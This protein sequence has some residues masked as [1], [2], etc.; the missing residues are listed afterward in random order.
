[1][2]KQRL[3]LLLVERNLI[4][5]RQQARAIIMS[6]IVEVE[7]RTITK[8]G[9]AV[10][11]EAK[12]KL[13]GRKNPYVSRGGLKL[14]KALE[15]FNIKVEGKIAG[16][17]GASTGGFTD[18]LLQ[19]GAI[20]VYSI[21][22]GYGQL[23]I[24]LRQDPRVEVRERVNIRYM[25]PSVIEERLQL[26]TVDVSFISLAKVMKPI[27]EVLCP[28]AEVIVLIK[29]QFEASPSF[30][31]KGVIQN[32]DQHIK[33][34]MEVLKTIREYGLSLCGLTFS[35][36]KGPAGNIEFFAFFINKLPLEGEMEAIQIEKVV[37][38]AHLFFKKS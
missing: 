34:I 4:E 10:R 16:D 25:K 1:M 35:P 28:E 38:E 11:K 29:P 6:G 22:V 8:P 7:G 26:A 27:K 17:F 23:D 12:I 14:E 20:K 30:V 21:D 2:G 31:K 24:K 33:I 32:P 15:E 3:D 5:S 36:L 18:C 37:T 19:K 13:Q 9:T